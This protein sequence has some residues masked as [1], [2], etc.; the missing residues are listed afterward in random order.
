MVPCGGPSLSATTIPGEPRRSLWGRWWRLRHHSEEETIS[1]KTKTYPEWVVTDSEKKLH[2]DF[3]YFLWFIQD[4]LKKKA[5]KRQF[6]D[7]LWLQHGPRRRMVQGFRGLGKSWITT[8]FVLWRLYRDPNERVLVISANEYKATEFSVFTRRLIEDVELLHF[9]RPRAGQRD[10]T[11]AFDV[12]PSDPSL[13]PSVRASGIFGQITGGRA[14]LIVPDD[15]EVPKNSL[16]EVMREKLAEAIKEFDAV[17]A[18]GGEIVYLGTP[19]TEQSIYR[20]LPERGYQIRVFPA[21]YP[22]AKLI[23]QY[24]G[25]LAPEIL[26]ELK[27][28][29]SLEGRSTDPE[30]FSDLDLAERL[31][32]YRAA[33]FSLQFMLDTSLSDAE[34]H[35]LKTHDMICMDVDVDRKLP[36]GTL[37]PALGPAKLLWTSMQDHVVTDIDNVG[38]TGDRLYRPLHISETMLPFQGRLMVIDPSGRGKDETAYVVLYHLNGMIYLKAVGGFK[39]GYEDDTLKGLAAVAAEHRVNDVLIESNFGDGMFAQLLR[40]HLSKVHPC[41]IEEIRATGQKELRII[42]DIEPV[43]AQHRLVI[44]AKAARKDAQDGVN[45]L[46]YQLTHITRDRGALRHDDRVDALAHG[47]RFFWDR[48]NRDVLTAEEEHLE[49]LR[50]EQMRNFAEKWYGVRNPKPHFAMTNPAVRR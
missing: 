50:D 30:R 44:D 16:T 14:S 31:A 9:L 46:L 29:P 36:D 3:R 25:T 21:K 22:S 23:E 10:S 47:L 34:K 26:E 48:L 7:A 39:G 8:A 5:T 24:A 28:D 37:S 33:G 49:R 20:L 40:P 38:F 4:H 42:D 18:P 2:D 13:A 27:A 12:G 6:Q 15:V 1:T 17:L 32:S 45:S 43:L 35:P 41:S 19:Q 11:L